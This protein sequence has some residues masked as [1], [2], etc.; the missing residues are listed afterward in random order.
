VL[1]GG[2]QYAAA[3]VRESLRLRPILPIVNRYV[4]KPTRVGGVDVPAGVTVAANVFLAHLR[5]EWQDP[6]SFR[7]ERFLDDVVQQSLW[8]PFGGGVRRCLGANFALLE[9]Q[10]IVSAI[11]RGVVLEAKRNHAARVVKRGFSFAPAKGTPSRVRGVRAIPTA[12]T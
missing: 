7:P 1:S 3:V 11:V 6:L 5:N 8:L 10:T 2:E 4:A 12:T 9:T